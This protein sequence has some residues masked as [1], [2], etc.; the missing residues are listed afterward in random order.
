MKYP[1]T[2]HLPQSPG[3]TRDDRRLADLDS[4]RGRALVLTEKLDGSNVCLQADAC[5]ARSHGQAPTHPSFDAFKAFHARVKDRIGADLQIFG[6]WLYA[7]H[8]IHYTALTSY[9]M[10]FGV[11]DMS[12]MRWASWAEVELW[13]EELGV[14]TAPVL[15]KAD[16]SVSLEALIRKF[17]TDGDPVSKMGGEREGFVVRWADEFADEDFERAVAK[18]VRAD[19]VQTPHHWKTTE[20]IRNRMA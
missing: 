9:F 3:G 19:H 6:E 4:L 12:K 15:F 18:F 14:P 11:R 10:L 17:G 5:Y 2:P 13:A 20:L 16:P 8:S 7:K 1:R